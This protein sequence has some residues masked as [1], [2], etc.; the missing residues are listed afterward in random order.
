MYRNAWEEI[1]VQQIENSDI[2]AW[3]QKIAQAKTLKVQSVKFCYPLLCSK[4]WLGR[5]L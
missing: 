4:M 3:F 5:S 2:S 1:S